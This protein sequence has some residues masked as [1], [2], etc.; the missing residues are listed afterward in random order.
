MDNIEEKN[1]EI[2]VTGATGRIGRL[3]VDEL[4]R[5]GVH[6]RALTRRL[7]QAALPAGVEVMSG[8]LTIP[9]SVDQALEGASAV[10]LVWTPAAATAPD[11]VK[12]L[13]LYSSPKPRR[14]V[15]L[16]S[17][18]Q[19]LHPFFQQPNPMRD[20]HIEIER[21]L[22]AAV[23]IEV[24]VLRPGMFASNTRHWWAAQIRE[25]NIVRWPYAS[26]ETAPID[27]RDIAA[28]AA[29]VL[30]D[31]RYTRGDFVLT[32]PESLSQAAQVHAIGNAIGK[33]LQLEELSPDEFR[34]F[35]AGTWPAV[36]VDMLLDA[37]KA[38]LGQP[39]YV[40]SSVKEILGLPPRTFYQWAAD[41]A[42]AFKGG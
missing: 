22:A 15:Y 3:V 25:S 35:T 2:L 32:G 28:V 40:T 19:T 39:A 27:E 33:P 26:A 1:R 29:R 14:V 16:S 30:L 17:P 6:V 11:F 20:L 24:V 10:F 37:W 5:T 18:H 21:L 34:R 8:D 42:S 9:D 31:D 41:N 13:T 36:V 38:T 23:G 4:L 12:R 7:E